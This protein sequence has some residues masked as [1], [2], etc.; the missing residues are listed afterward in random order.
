M[1]VQLQI[2]QN[3]SRKIKYVKLSK[4][5]TAKKMYYWT[6]APGSLQLDKSK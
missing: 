4:K 6:I 1:R 3:C 2:D 5:M